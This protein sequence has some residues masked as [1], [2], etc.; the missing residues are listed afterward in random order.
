PRPDLDDCGRRPTNIDEAACSCEPRLVEMKRVDTDRT[1]AREHVPEVLLDEEVTSIE[2]VEIE[3][4]RGERSPGLHRGRGRHG[5]LLSREGGDRAV[6][7]RRRGLIVGLE[8]E[9]VGPQC[10][11]THRQKLA[12]LEDGRRNAVVALRERAYELVFGETVNGRLMARV[13]R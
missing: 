4:H 6:D 1:E 12:I 13:G 2:F 3:P 9:E 11:E 8:D 7:R 5:I 10:G